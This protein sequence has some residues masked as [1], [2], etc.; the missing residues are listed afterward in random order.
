MRGAG[1]KVSHPEGWRER[2]WTPTCEGGGMI[3]RRD[4]RW[5]GMWGLLPEGM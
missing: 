5:W 2:G 4:E 1:R 3:V